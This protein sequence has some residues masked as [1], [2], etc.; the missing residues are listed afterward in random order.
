MAPCSGLW[1]PHVVTPKPGPLAQAQARLGRPGRPRKHPLPAPTP[2]GAVG[3]ARPRGGPARPEEAP[4]RGRSGGDGTVA[5]PL[6]PRLL[7]LEATATY[8]GVSARTLRA[9]EG[10]GTLR[11]VEIPLGPGQVRKVLFDRLALDR[12]VDSWARG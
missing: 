1:D 12:L 10:A 3:G 8:L 9:L 5:G 4:L 2:A 11:R 6:S 7:G